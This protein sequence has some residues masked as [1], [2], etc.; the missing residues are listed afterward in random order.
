MKAEQPDP[1][2]HS[3]FYAA[4]E[5]H[6]EFHIHNAWSFRKG[7][8]TEATSG[9]RKWKLSSINNTP[10]SSSLLAHILFPHPPFPFSSHTYPS[11]LFKLKQTNSIP[12]LTHE[13]SPP[14]PFSRISSSYSCLKKLKKL[15]F[16]PRVISPLPFPRSPRALDVIRQRSG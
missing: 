7:I 5:S 8:Q 10:P 13:S 6:S 4:G 9:K 1:A 3:E 16:S 2:Q 14:L 12:S 11:C 15:T